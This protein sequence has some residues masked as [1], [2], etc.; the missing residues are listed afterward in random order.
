MV[1]IETCGCHH[2]SLAAFRFLEKTGLFYDVPFVSHENRSAS[3]P[4]AGFKQI[5]LDGTDFGTPR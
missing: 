2:V 5:R 4:L 3:V 1:T